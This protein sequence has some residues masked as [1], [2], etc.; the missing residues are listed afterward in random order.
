M[1]G[2]FYW[3]SLPGY[4]RILIHV[5]EQHEDRDSRV[6]SQKSEVKLFGWL[7]HVLRDVVAS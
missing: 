3:S 1:S 6:E 2:G 4:E 7:E 5:K